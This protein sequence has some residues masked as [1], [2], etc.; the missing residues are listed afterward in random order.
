MAAL[1]SGIWV[2]AYIRRLQLSDIAVFVAKHGDDDA[3]AV[4]V[5]SNTL[6]GQARLFQRSFDMSGQRIWSTLA[7]GTDAAVESTIQ[8]QC[9]FDRDIWVLEVEDRNGRTLLDEDGLSG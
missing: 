4:L 5:K 6:D 1:K 7:E 3:G 8:K 2:A 9:G